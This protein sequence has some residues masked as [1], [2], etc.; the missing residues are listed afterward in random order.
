MQDNVCNRLVPDVARGG[1][2][3]IIEARLRVTASYAK[4]I[5]TVVVPKLKGSA[6]RAWINVPQRSE[7]RCAIFVVRVDPVLESW[8]T[9]RQSAAS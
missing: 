9:Y 3:E 1:S 2:A 4:N 7:R 5:V 6:I 8:L